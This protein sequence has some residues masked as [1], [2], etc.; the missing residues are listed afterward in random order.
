MLDACVCVCAFRCVR[1]CAV[2]CPPVA[3]SGHVF[4]CVLKAVSK[5]PKKVQL[6]NQ[7][8]R[9]PFIY[10]TQIFRNLA[11]PQTCLYYQLAISPRCFYPH[12]HSFVTLHYSVVT[13]TPAGTIRRYVVQ[14]L[15]RESTALHLPTFSHLVIVNKLSSTLLDFGIE[16]PWLTFAPLK[17]CKAMLRILVKMLKTRERRERER[18]NVLSVTVS[19][20][21]TLL[22][23]STLYWNMNFL[24]LILLLGAPAMVRGVRTECTSGHPSRAKTPALSW[25]ILEPLRRSAKPRRNRRVNGGNR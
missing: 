18:K 1:R 13:Q 10:K 8:C 9:F 15:F 14:K 20:F 11:Y 22:F 2:R 7:Q 6:G 21:S 4:R 3:V 16:L 12:A 25:L 5:G 17:R 23:P 19:T 24:F